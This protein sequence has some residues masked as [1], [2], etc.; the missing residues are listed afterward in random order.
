MHVWQDATRGCQAGLVHSSSSYGNVPQH[1]HVLDHHPDVAGD[2][3]AVYLVHGSLD[4]ATS[5][6]RVVR[7]LPELRVVSY[8]RRGYNRSRRM[9]VGTLAD[10]VTDLVA[11]VG[12]GPAVVIG[13]SFGG[14]VALGAAVA[15]PGSVVGVGAYEPPM[16]WLEWWPRRPRRGDEDPARFAED[17]FRRLVGE[18]SWDRLPEATRDERRADGPALMAELTSLRAHPAPFDPAMLRVPAVFGRGEHS[19]W[20]HRRGVEELQ[21]TVAGSEIFEVAGAAHGAHLSHPGGFADMVRQLMSRVETR[22]P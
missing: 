9:P 21:H 20:H 4:R 18:A 8:D 11:L 19:V 22:S 2:R 12:R 16:P 17:F 7:R 15:A 6:S 1:L 5:F 14:D 13:H 10:H 3:P